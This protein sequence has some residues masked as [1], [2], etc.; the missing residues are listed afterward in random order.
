MSRLD[1]GLRFSFFLM[2]TLSITERFRTGQAANCTDRDGFILSWQEY[3]ST[4]S[5]LLNMR[6]K[7]V[8]TNL[9]RFV[10]KNKS[11]KKFNSGMLADLSFNFKHTV[12]EKFAQLQD[13]VQLTNSY[14]SVNNIL[15]YCVALGS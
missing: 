15:V 13:I 6:F 5:V 4:F 1:P 7:F 14:R 11:K 2:G 10:E 3:G 8:I 12:D 9:I